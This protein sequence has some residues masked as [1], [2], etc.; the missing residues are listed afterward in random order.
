MITNREK[1]SCAKREVGQR[2][3]VYGR[4]VEAGTMKKVAADREIA[5]M[6][7]IADDYEAL[8]QADEAKGRLL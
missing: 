3:Y 1:A 6:Q 8:A 4:R 7:A 2:K 5:V